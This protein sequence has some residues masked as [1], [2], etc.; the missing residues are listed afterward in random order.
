MK[1]SKSVLD[2]KQQA[3]P[4]QPKG[5]TATTSSSGY[6]VYHLFLVGVMALVLG[7]YV[8]LTYFKK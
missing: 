3:M 7:A 2:M 4:N 8:S 5:R 1:D 6:Q